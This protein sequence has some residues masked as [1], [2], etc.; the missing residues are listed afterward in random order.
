[1]AAALR[2]TLEQESPPA[3][4]Q[5]VRWMVSLTNQGL[6]P[7]LDV[8]LEVTLPAAMALSEAQSAVGQT[9]TGGGTVRWYLPRLEPGA[10]AELLLGGQ[11]TQIPSPDSRLCALLLSDASP[12]EHCYTLRLAPSAGTLATSQ[13]LPASAASDLAPPAPSTP[14][15]PVPGLAG[16]G[17]VIAGL[18]VLG[19]WLG[20]RLAGDRRPKERH[21][22]RAGD[23]ADAGT[24]YDAKPGDGA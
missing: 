8:T 4:G 9:I 13:P 21:A 7:A 19:A 24:A 18:A 16:W 12:L 15:S 14:A 20:L 6:T 2:I 11:L 23:G 22:A 10:T 3:V 1:M 17:L 5:V